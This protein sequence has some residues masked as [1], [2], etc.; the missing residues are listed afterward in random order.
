MKISLLSFNTTTPS[1]GLKI[2]IRL[3]RGHSGAH[4]TLLFSIEDY[5]DDPLSQGSLGVGIC[6]E[7]GVEAFAKGEEGENK[8]EVVFITGNGDCRL[9]EEVLKYLSEEIPEVLGLSWELKI[10]LEL[11]TSQGFGMSASGAIAAAEAFQ[12][13]IGIPYEECRRRA[14]LI[15]H[16]VERDRST[17]LGD[18]TALSAGGVERRIKAGSPY[19]GKKLMKGPGI[20]EGWSENIPVLLVWKERTGTHTAD[21][22]DNKNWRGKISNAGLA[23]MNRL[24]EGDWNRNRWK[25]ILSSSQKFVEESK[26]LDDLS[27]NELREITKNCLISMGI[28]NKFVPLLC[29][30]G[31]SIAIV[32]KDVSS[33][34]EEIT[35]ISKK[36][37]NLGVLT[38]LSRIGEVRN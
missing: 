24:S 28:E 8:L 29:M 27:R 4:L 15:A 38:A 2:M 31:E 30:L 35:L 17:G 6:L 25:E 21:Y 26:L 32:P 34:F 7:D 10:K 1:V 18:T 36:L 5:S 19:S 14:L 33:N 3:G 23:Q 12:R 9:Y 37:Q 16:L 13:A 11:P 22:I 20:S